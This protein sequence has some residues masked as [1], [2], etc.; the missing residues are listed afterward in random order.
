MDID[1]HASVVCAVTNIWAS[2]GR[3]E[4]DLEDPCELVRM[5][6]FT[7]YRPQR[8]A[9]EVYLPARSYHGLWSVYS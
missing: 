3:S 5:M 8:K 2:F 4:K 9:G 1:L 6:T 7:S